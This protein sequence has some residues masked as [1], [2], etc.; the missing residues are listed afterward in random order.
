MIAYCYIQNKR[1]EPGFSNFQVTINITAGVTL[2]IPA[3]N[4]YC[5]IINLTGTS[6]LTFNQIANIPPLVPFTIYPAFG[7]F[8]T[9]DGTPYPPGTGYIA[10]PTSNV[11]LYGSF[12]SW[13][14]FQIDPTGVGFAQQINTQTY[15]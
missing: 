13:I 5:G 9:F 4:I 15:L 8:V 7:M 12:G 3:A 2:T 10:L 6:G 14:E 1:A 11:V